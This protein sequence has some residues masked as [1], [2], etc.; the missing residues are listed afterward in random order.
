MKRAAQRSAPMNVA[1]LYPAIALATMINV[2]LF[3]LAWRGHKIE[4]ETGNAPW[5]MYVEIIAYGGAMLVFLYFKHKVPIVAYFDL[6][7]TAM[8][9]ELMG[10]G[11][12]YGILNFFYLSRGLN[13]VER[14]F[15]FA[16]MVFFVGLFGA[17]FFV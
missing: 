15:A 3:A 16:Q 1:E 2:F 5:W 17:G 8:F 4:Q 7:L 6:V 13:R 12:V 10:V 9:G 14:F 11:G